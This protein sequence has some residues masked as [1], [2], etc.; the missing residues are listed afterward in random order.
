[1]IQQNFLQRVFLILPPIQAGTT[2]PTSLLPPGL[3]LAEARK[4]GAAFRFVH[5]AP[6][7]VGT[8]DLLFAA[9][10]NGKKCICVQEQRSRRVERRGRPMG[11]RQQIRNRFKCWVCPILILHH[12]SRSWTLAAETSGLLSRTLPETAGGAHSKLCNRAATANYLSLSC[13]ANLV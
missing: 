5:F 9:Q 13:G 12:P 10:I 1:M 8:I 2:I 6:D 11:A 7:T 3:V 4:L